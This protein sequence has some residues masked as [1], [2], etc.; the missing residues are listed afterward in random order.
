M[1]VEF[2][3]DISQVLAKVNGTIQ[4]FYPVVER[5]MRFGT[6]LYLGE[7]EKK[8][9]RIVDGKLARMEEKEQ[10]EELPIMD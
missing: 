7:F 2:T 3:I 4:Q 8:Q 6:E 9:L 10:R 1:A 5:A